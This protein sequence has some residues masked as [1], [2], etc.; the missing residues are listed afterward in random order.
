[1]IVFRPDA[2]DS[3]R[4]HEMR[5]VVFLEKVSRGDNLEAR[6]AAGVRRDGDWRSRR[7]GLRVGDI[8]QRNSVAIVAVIRLRAERAVT[9]HDAPIEPIGAQPDAKPPAGW[10]VSEFQRRGNLK[11][12]KALDLVGGA[13]PDIRRE[14]LN[15]AGCSWNSKHKSRLV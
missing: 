6:I 2:N 9:L 11:V 1:M 5:A 7:I 4:P 15:I 14:N 3:L 12:A 13:V 8:R 10:A